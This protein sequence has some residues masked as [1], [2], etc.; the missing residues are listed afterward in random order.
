MP[1]HSSHT[2][3]RE[4]FEDIV[5]DYR[6]HVYNICLGMVKNEEDAEDLAQEVF[7]SAYKSYGAFKGESTALTWLYR[8]AVNKC[9]EANRRADRHKRKVATTS[10]E[11]VEDRGSSQ[12][13]HPGVELENRERSAILFEAMDKLPESQKVAFLLQQMEGMSQTQISSIMEKSESSV[14]SLLHR[15]KANLRNLLRKYY[16]EHR[17]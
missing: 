10:L 4:P 13:Y 2:I 17:R 11:M 15:A 16:E 7:V 3:P 12:F 5:K 1:V 14:E 6:N 9:L 8:I